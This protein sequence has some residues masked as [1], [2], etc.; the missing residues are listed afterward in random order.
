VSHRNDDRRGIWNLETWTP[1]RWSGLGLGSDA[2]HWLRMG[3]ST[4]MD[5]LALATRQGGEGFR[6]L[7]SA[8]RGAA[9]W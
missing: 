4:T 9:A 3:C 1:S 7:D 2:K 5:R 8:N 6:K